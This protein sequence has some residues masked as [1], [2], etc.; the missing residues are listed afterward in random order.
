MTMPHTPTPWIAHDANVFAGSNCIAICDTDNAPVARMQANA[1]HIVR[2][3]NA[4]DALVAV[5]R[6]VVHTLDMHGHIDGG[7]DLHERAYA[8][9]QAAQP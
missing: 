8:A 7:T 4:H 1:T 9:L 6:A 5:V 3:V 2:C